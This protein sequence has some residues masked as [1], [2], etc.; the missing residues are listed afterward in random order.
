[1]KMKLMLGLVL[2]FSLAL[3]VGNALAEDLSDGTGFEVVTDEGVTIL[4]G[5]IAC[6]DCG[7]GDCCD[8]DNWSGDKFKLE[9]KGGEISKDCNSDRCVYLYVT[10]KVKQW[11]YLHLEDT[12]FEWTVYK[13]GTY[14]AFLTDLCTLSNGS[15]SLMWTMIEDLKKYGENDIDAYYMARSMKITPDPNS[16]WW[17]NDRADGTYLAKNQPAC[18]H[19]W[20]VYGKIKVDDDHQ[21]VG[22][23][24]GKAKICLTLNENNGAFGS[25]I[26]N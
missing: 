23:Y 16:W 21:G 8:F 26:L 20:Y 14:V 13:P 25:I 15:T 7:Q 12:I 18:C 5:E 17:L 19:K 6:G 10:A 22:E 1:M 11:A 24:F 4:G 9:A 3:F 2:I